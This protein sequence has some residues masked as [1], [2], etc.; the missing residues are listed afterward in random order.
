MVAGW[1]SPA[2]LRRPTVGEPP[3]PRSRLLRR[4]A[5]HST[6]LVAL[7]T[8][9][10]TGA[11]LAW[12]LTPLG[13]SAV[14]LQSMAADDSVSVAQ[15]DGRL[16]VSPRS[17]TPTS[18]VIIYPGGRIEPRS[19]AP[20]ARRLATAGHLAVIVEAPL[21]LAILDA[22]AARAPIDAHPEIAT[23]VLSG[24]SLGGVAAAS[25]AR[26][27]ADRVQGLVLMASYPAEGSDLSDTD[28]EVL[29]LVGTL[30]EVVDRGALARA[31]KLLPWNTT[32]VTLGGGNHAQFGSYGTQ[33][34]DGQATISPEDQWGITVM[35]IEGLFDRVEGIRP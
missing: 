16:E 5:R 18:A 33:P 9:V 25:F 13:P 24:H 22:D 20:L 12:A 23:W 30:D 29:S 34:G 10:G 11:F 6:A 28:I 3:H 19:Y 31:D 17:V 26:E 2:S 32:Y 21:S 4:I 15:K 27:N 35:Q 14:A 8:V 7:V 1:N